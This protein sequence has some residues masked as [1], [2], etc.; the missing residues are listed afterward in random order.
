MKRKNKKR[1]KA[2]DR[3]KASEILLNNNSKTKP[4]MVIFN[5]NAGKK[6]HPI[7]G[8]NT[9]DEI[10]RLMDKYQI[11][12]DF[13]VTKGPGDATKLVREANN[14]TYEII[15]SAG[16]DGTVSEVASGLIGR[17]FTL[18]IL[19]LGTYMNITQML[20]IPFDLEKAVMLLKIGRTR[21]IDVGQITMLNGVKPRQS[22]YFMEN[23]SV[24]F[25]AELQE[26]TMLYDKR[27]FL[28]LLIKLYRIKD[29]FQHKVKIIMDDQEVEDKA[30]MVSVS[31]GQY[32]GASMK[33]APTAKLNDHI[34]NISVFHMSKIELFF[35]FIKLISH[36]K[37][38]SSKITRYQ[39]NSVEIRTVHPKPMHADGYIFGQTPVAYKILPSAL[40]VI[41]GFPDLGNKALKKRNQLDP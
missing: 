21:E 17:D 38:F 13:F 22:L 25:E 4:I 40:N 30:T 8:N 15:V 34:L 14:K 1:E 41:T 20:S 27:K 37:S 3:N 28:P 29:Y 12:A 36:G 24:G 19:P 11:P 26:A 5:P 39:S 18:G 7:G 33:L 31:N 6:K 16:G 9:L 10:K 2:V 35:Y 23:S 32:T